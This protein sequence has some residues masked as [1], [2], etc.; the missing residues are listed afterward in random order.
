MHKKYKYV[1]VLWANETIFSKNLIYGINEYTKKRNME[2]NLFV[3]PYKNVYDNFKNDIDNIEYIEVSNPKSAEVVNN[4]GEFADWIFLHN[5]CGHFELLKIKRKFLSKI[6]WRYWGGATLGYIEKKG[7]PIKNIGYSVVDMLVKKR[8]KKFK[9]VGIANFVDEVALTDRF[10]NLNYILMPYSEFKS[11]DILNSFKTCIKKTETINVMIG[12]SGYSEDKH[13]EIS[14]E[15]LKFK[16]RNIKLHIMLSYGDQKYISE[17]KEKIRKSWGDQVFIYEDLIPYQ[18]YVRIL[19][20]IDIAFLTG[21]NSYALGNISILLFLKKKIFLD[22]NGILA[23]AFNTLQIP[24]CALQE[25]NN[26]SYEQFV[27]PVEYTSDSW[28]KLSAQKDQNFENLWEKIFSSLD[29][30]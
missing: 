23:Q 10:G 9:A 1:H 14:N 25:L 3:T 12:H 21:L 13:I 20:N 16:D 15:L 7:N 8:V 30:K 17:I 22:E 24:F 26:Y 18:D 2:T 11:Y 4:I 28:K 6:I 29:I 27:S 5:I 19:S